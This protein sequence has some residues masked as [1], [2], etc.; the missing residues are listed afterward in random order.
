[1]YRH[2]SCG[3][4]TPCREGTYW[5]ETI[6]TTIEHGE[7]TSDQIDHLY[8]LCDMILGKSFCA[9]GD[10]AAMPVMSVIQKFREEFEFHVRAK[11][12]G[13]NRRRDALRALEERSGALV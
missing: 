11:R 5:M 9:L 7:G 3:K 13:S 4:C 10:A 6:L 1:F 2:E 8:G 12:C